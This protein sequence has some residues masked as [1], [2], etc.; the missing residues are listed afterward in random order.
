MAFALEQAGARHSHFTDGRLGSGGDTKSYF[1]FCN[2]VC[3][4]PDV[5][6]GLRHGARVPRSSWP[7]FVPAFLCDLE[8]VDTCDKRGHD[9]SRV[10]MPRRRLASPAIV[11]R[12]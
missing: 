2:S 4:V 5:R 3:P 11:I 1:G 12:Q 7:G 9:A 6:S 8:D 10:A